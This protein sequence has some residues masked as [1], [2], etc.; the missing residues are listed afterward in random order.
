MSRI[1]SSPHGLTRQTLMRLRRRLSGWV[2]ASSRETNRSGHGNLMISAMHALMHSGFKVPHIYDSRAC[3]VL[4]SSGLA[5][6]RR[7]GSRSRAI[8]RLSLPA[9]ASRLSPVQPSVLMRLLIAVH[10]PSMA[11]RSR[12]WQAGQMLFT[13]VLMSNSSLALLMRVS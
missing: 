10:S 1:R 7:R 6:P 12:Y 5:R 2:Y 4:Q 8:G 13:R 3:V 9:S 11:S